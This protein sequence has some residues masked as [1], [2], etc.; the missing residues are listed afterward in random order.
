MLLL[1]AADLSQACPMADAIAA[2]RQGFADLS[3]GR[4]TVPVRVSVPLAGDGVA[5]AMPAA[6][7][8]G[9]Y[10]S[11]KVVAVAPGNAARGL[12]L[13]PA[14][15]LLGDAGTGAAL[16]LIEGAALTALRTGAAG[17]V[18][19]AVL[20]RSD[21]EVATVFGAGVQARA[22]ILALATVLQGKLREIRV[23]G[24]GG[25]RAHGLIDWALGLEELKGLTLR[26]G[27]GT[28][29]E[30]WVREAMEGADVVVTAT[31]SATP[32]FDGGHLGEGVHIT[33]V[34]SFKPGMRE[35]DA[36]TLAGA[37]IV[38]DQR[39]AALAEA[40]ELQGLGNEDVV[41]IGEV[42][43]GR[44]VGRTSPSERTVF[45]SVGNAV[46]DLVVAS[47]AYERARDLGL[48]EEISWP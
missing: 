5:L 39:E 15:V 16:A 7:A 9:S 19:A 10:F 3:A 44:E 31:S 43:S 17:G 13:V 47:R 41:E 11:V 8:G 27:S 42:I 40:G 37:R 34:G 1:R 30:T 36:E 6:L 20:A 14:T 25:E 2:V 46:Q 22:Q 26:G 23:V 35:L 29:H 33:A 24:R 32:V 4:A 45:K 12:P 28:L 48:G 21:S 18:A 38:V